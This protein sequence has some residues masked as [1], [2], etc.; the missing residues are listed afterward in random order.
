MWK[1]C[2]KAATWALSSLYNLD[3]TV[4]CTLTIT[5]LVYGV[6]R[7]TRWISRSTLEH[8]VAAEAIRPVPWQ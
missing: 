4:G 1:A 2:S 6:T 8:T 5:F 7:I 3:T